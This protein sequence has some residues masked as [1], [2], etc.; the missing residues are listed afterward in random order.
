V[1][2]GLLPLIL[3]VLAS[4]GGGD[5]PTPPAAGVPIPIPTASSNPPPA[6]TG[7]NEREIVPQAIDA[8][9]ADT[10]PHVIINAA[11]AG[12][13]G[14]L[15]VMLPGTRG[16]ARGYRLILREGAAR[17]YH[18]IGLNYDNPIAVNEV[19]PFSPDPDCAGNMRREIIEG[20]DRSPLVAVAPPASIIGRLTTLLTHLAQTAPNEGWDAFLTGGQPNWSRIS[21]GGHSQGSG[22]AGLM[23]KLL[24]LDRAVMFSG[25]GDLG[26]QGRG[27]ADWL[28]LPALTPAARLYGFTHRADELVPLALVQTQ[29]RTL[30]L[31][32]FG[33]AVEVDGGTAYAGPSRQLL[34]TVPPNPA[35]STP[36]DSPFHGATVVDPVTPLDAAG[37]PL[38]AATWVYLAFP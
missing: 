2:T 27:I 5:A 4:C 9:V 29:W 37:R 12:A 3:F 16:P 35:G 18:A 22:H 1:K 25:P 24:V 19:C 7:A 38:F 33:A 8:R 6:P 32:A 20:A 30:G 21:V 36:S 34:T 23:S 28:S 10:R 17:G 31:E 14:R 13:K 26:L 15:F 11:S